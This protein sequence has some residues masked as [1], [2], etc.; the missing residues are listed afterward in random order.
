M[1]LNEIFLK[2]NMISQ[3]LLNIAYDPRG[4]LLSK[5]PFLFK[6]CNESNLSIELRKVT[7]YFESTI[8]T[9]SSFH[10]NSEFYYKFNKY[11][12][13][14][15][16]ENIPLLYYKRTTYFFSSVLAF[17]VGH[18]SFLLLS[19]TFSLYSLPK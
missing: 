19:F 4:L 2:A 16:G 12:Y 13:C 3:Y 15:I 1:I 18:G 9:Y 17:S 5:N 10:M 11:D 7:Q 14:V 8:I 6:F